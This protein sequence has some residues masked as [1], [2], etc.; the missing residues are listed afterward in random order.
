MPG[1]LSY[2]AWHFVI[3]A[4]GVSS[5]TVLYDEDSLPTFQGGGYECVD[6]TVELFVPARGFLHGYFKGKRN[7]PARVVVAAHYRKGTRGYR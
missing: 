7:R 6:R 2:A 3:N 1:L 5:V 4:D